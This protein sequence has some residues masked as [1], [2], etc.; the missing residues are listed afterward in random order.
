M[1]P[2]YASLQ[3]DN[4]LPDKVSRKWHTPIHNAKE[5]TFRIRRTWGKKKKR[6]RRS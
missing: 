2:L 4:F 5:R 6:R 1:P 3:L